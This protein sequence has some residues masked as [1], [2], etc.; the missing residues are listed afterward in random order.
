[1]FFGVVLSKVLA[2]SGHF[3]HVALNEKRIMLGSHNS[4]FYHQHGSTYYV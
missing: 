1:M 4:V 2:K 3:I